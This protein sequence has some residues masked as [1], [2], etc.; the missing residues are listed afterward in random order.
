MKLHSC[1]CKI[2]KNRRL[3]ENHSGIKTVQEKNGFFKY[4]WKLESWELNLRIGILELNLKEIGIFKIIWELEL[5]KLN[6]EN[7]NLRNY[8][9][10]RYLKIDKIII[11]NKCEN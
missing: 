3:F 9:K 8:L 7:W 11:I 4:I 2:K 5:W 1:L 10:M 6:Y